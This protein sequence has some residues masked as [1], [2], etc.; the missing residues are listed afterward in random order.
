[1]RILGEG[2][3]TWRWRLNR[4]G[5]VTQLRLNRPEAANAVNLETVHELTA[6][7]EAFAADEGARVLVVTGAGDRS[8]CGGGDLADMLEFTRHADADRAGPLGFARLDPGK[9][10]IAAVNGHCFG[11]GLELALWCDF[12][13]AARNASFGALN[14]P[15]GLPLIDGGT[16]RLPRIVG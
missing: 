3:G 16:Q 14:R 15:W 13:I 8:F 10:T 1:M 6:A 9:P 12:R 4:P 11:G 7:I 5:P 2:G